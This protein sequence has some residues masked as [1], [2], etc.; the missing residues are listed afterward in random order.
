MSAPTRSEIANWDGHLPRTLPQ[1]YI[2]SSTPSSFSPESF[3]APVENQDFDDIKNAFPRGDFREQKR[4]EQSLV[5]AG[6]ESLRTMYIRHAIDL[7]IQLP[8]IPSLYH[9]NSPLTR[10]YMFPASTTLLSRPVHANT[11]RYQDPRSQSNQ[12]S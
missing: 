11:R 4:F 12:K 5:H 10:L 2:S 8:H 6:L 9:H 7:C 1:S 3:R